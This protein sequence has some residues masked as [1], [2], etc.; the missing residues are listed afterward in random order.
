MPT[1]IAK[2]R[3]INR[4][5]LTPLQR[6]QGFNDDWNEVKFSDVFSFQPTNSLSRDA[7]TNDAGEIKNIHYGDIHTKYRS[8]FFI[9]KE[10]VPYVKSNINLSGV[11]EES[12]CKVGDVVIAD[13]SEDYQDI[14]KAIEIIEI[15][16]QKILAGLHTFIARPKSNTFVL[17]FLAYLMRAQTMRLQIMTL[18]QG[19]KV[20]G[21]S[22]KYLNE[23]LFKIPSL[24]EQQRIASFLSSVDEWIENLHLQKESLEKYKKGM[25]QKLFSQQIRFK[26]ENG[27]N[28]PDWEEKRLNELVRI[29]MGQSPSSETYNEDKNGVYLI[30]GNADLK[31]RKTSPR[32][33]TSKPTK[34][35]DKGDLIM[36][37]RAPVGYLAKCMHKVCIGRGVAAFKPKK[38][39]SIT[40]V[41]QLL[42]YYEKKWVKYEQGSTFTA[43]N[44][45][46]VNHLKLLVPSVSEQ[47]QIASILQVLDDEI[48]LKSNEI[49]SVEDW[50]KGLMQRMF[51]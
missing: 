28:Y 38:E 36:T 20:L 22:T 13:A 41:Y 19:T 39:A 15:D 8:R 10:E 3:N 11:S 6:F 18:A 1:T 45:R 7:L 31:D 33:W 29:E 49:S 16:N 50:K 24:P 12:Y 4:D 46:D 44:T 47:E 32:I 21:I 43:I 37:V 25:M 14:G 23:I 26:D 35:A 5:V 34:L 27:K 40:F 51:I 42:L 2:H 48:E 17:G 9:N 30:Q